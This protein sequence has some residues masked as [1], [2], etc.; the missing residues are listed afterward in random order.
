MTKPGVFIPIAQRR[1]PAQKGEPFAQNAKAKV[2]ELRLGEACLPTKSGHLLLCLMNQQ[3]PPRFVQIDPNKDIQ[4]K[5]GAPPESTTPL[6][7][8]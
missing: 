7:H 5:G 1:K 6:T 2:T 3:L 8:L 4:P